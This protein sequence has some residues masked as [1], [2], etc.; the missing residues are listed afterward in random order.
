MDKSSIARRRTGCRLSVR[1]Q[2]T[3]QL[4]KNLNCGKFFRPLS[5]LS[6][7]HGDDALKRI[8]YSRFRV[9]YKDSIVAIGRAIK[10]PD[11]HQPAS[12]QISAT[13]RASPHEC[14]SCAMNRS[15]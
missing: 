11:A 14:T 13:K 4:Q 9:R 8:S 1:T 12:V 7:R 10:M 6:V 3:E 5:G 2:R 15:L